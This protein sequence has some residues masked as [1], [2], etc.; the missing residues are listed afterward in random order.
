MTAQKSLERDQDEG[1]TP[2]KHQSS[3][4]MNAGLEAKELTHLPFYFFQY[5]TFHVF[6][7]YPTSVDVR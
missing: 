7:P 1:L 2:G 4:R 6:S 5:S 3:G